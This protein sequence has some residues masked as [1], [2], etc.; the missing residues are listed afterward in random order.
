M[1]VIS[2]PKKIASQGDL[3]MITRKEYE[4]LLAQTKRKQDWIYEPKVVAHIKKRATEASKDRT[5]GTMIKWIPK[6]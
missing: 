3:V 2:I 6:K 1:T 5:K 4:N